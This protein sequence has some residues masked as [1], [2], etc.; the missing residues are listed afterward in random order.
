MLQIRVIVNVKGHKEEFPASENLKFKHDPLAVGLAYDGMHH[1]IYWTT[2]QEGQQSIRSGPLHLPGSLAKE[3]TTRTLI[4]DHDRV[5]NP[6]G[7]AF[8]HLGG[9]LYFTNTNNWGRKSFIGVINVH[10]EPHEWIELITHDVHQPRGIAVVPEEGLLFYADWGN[11]PALVRANMDGSNVKR[12]VTRDIKWINGVAVDKGSRRLYW[13]DAQFDIIESVNFEGEDRR[14]ILE[15]VRHPVFIDVFENTLYWSDWRSRELL[16][17]DKFTGGNVT[18]LYKSVDELPTG[19]TI[20]HPVR[21]PME[22]NPCHSGPLCSHFCLLRLES[23]GRVGRACHCP[24]KWLLSHDGVTCQSPTTLSLEVPA[25]ESSTS[26]SAFSHTTRPSITTSTTTTSQSITQVSIL[27]NSSSE[28]DIALSTTTTSQE[29]IVIVPVMTAANESLSDILMNS[30]TDTNNI[31]SSAIVK[32]SLEEKD[33][34][35]D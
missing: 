22:P 26:T 20:Y 16:A 29:N 35:R 10:K 14:M 21:M 25:D 13:T 24:E 1:Q 5:P 30:D 11:S 4:L 12:I 31:S 15:G 17:C 34:V 3:R 2:I 27:S 23:D 6:E 8:D 9:N 18:V 19:L 28:E 7:L 32:S 33:E